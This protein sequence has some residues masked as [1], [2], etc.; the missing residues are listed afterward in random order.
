M[1]HLFNIS[2]LLSIAISSSCTKHLDRE[3]AMQQLIKAYGYPTTKTYDLAKTYIKDEQSDGPCLSIVIPANGEQDMENAIG[4]FARNGLLKLVEEP[5]RAE[6]SCLFGTSV[7]TWTSVT[8]LLTA[9]GKPYLVQDDGQHYR[10]KLWDTNITAVTGIQEMEE[11]KTAQAIYT[12]AN[13]NITPF[14]NFFSDRNSVQQST[15]AFAL[16]DDGWRL[17]R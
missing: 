7:R 14:A 12:I 11:S 2:L 4:F 8:V 16:F 6:S 15:A 17:Q 5:H 13:Q 1:K 9:A 10:V 3:Q